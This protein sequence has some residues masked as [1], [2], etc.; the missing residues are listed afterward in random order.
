[1]DELPE[2]VEALRRVPFF[3]DLTPEDLHRMARIGQRRTFAPGEEIVTKD[4]E[5]GGLF[6]LL[7]GTA[8]VRTGGATHTLQPGAFFGEMSLLANKPRSASVVAAEPVEAMTIEAM[9]FKPFLIKNPSVAVT[10]LSVVAE[11][12][13]EVQ[14]RIERAGADPAGPS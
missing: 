2:E 13:R 7:S 8:T 14:D 6:V 10:I 5:G 12:L 1:M 11:R 4:A 3:E 9:Y